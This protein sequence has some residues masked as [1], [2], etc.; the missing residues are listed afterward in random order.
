MSH[1]KQVKDYSDDD[2]THTLAII[3]NVSEHDC[4]ISE[5]E[6]TYIEEDTLEVKTGL[7]VILEVPTLDTDEQV[8]RSLEDLADECHGEQEFDI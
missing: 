4:F 2:S 5:R 6:Y 3:T 1:R 7:E 8:Y